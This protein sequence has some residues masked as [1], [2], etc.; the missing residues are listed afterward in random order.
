LRLAIFGG[1]FDPIHKAHVAMARE[2]ADQFQLDKVL[3]IPA[4]NPPHK[5]GST[6]APYEDRL[7]MAEVACAGE[8]RFRISR[9]EEGPGRSYSIDTI[10][11]VRATL[12]AMDELFF[13]IGADAFAEMESWHRWREVV[14]A[15]RFIVVSRPGHC[16]RIP[17][18]ASVE[19]LETVDLPVSSSD[20]RSALAAGRR[21]AEI[22]KAVL[23]YIHQHGLYGVPAG[24]YRP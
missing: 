22:P 16:Y 17:E 9:L 7:R 8:P 12:S 13:L 10:E 11:R 3:F 21:P 2:A 19:R 6:Y 20:I 4:S 24:A 1:T 14:A 23:T 15:V 5:S 18:G